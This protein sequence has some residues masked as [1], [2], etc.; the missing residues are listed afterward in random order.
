LK[1]ELTIT[2]APMREAAMIESRC[3]SQGQGAVITFSGVVRESEGEEKISGLE[4]EC[5]QAM[6][7]RQFHLIFDAIEKRWP[8]ES[9]RLIHRIG[10]VA[11]GESSLWVE[12]I[13]PHRGE[14]FAACQWLIDEMKRVV[15]IWKKVIAAK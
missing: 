9:V 6:A 7:E 3:L 15:P 14:A 12:V 10:P 13:A 4:Y 5:F 8:I 1:R 2:K 11:A